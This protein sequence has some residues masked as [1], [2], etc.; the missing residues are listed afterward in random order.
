MSVVFLIKKHE[1]S[2]KYIDKKEGDLTCSGLMYRTVPLLPVRIPSLF[3]NVTS[4][5]SPIFIWFL[6]TKNMLPGYRKQKQYLI[7]KYQFD[8]WLS[9]IQIICSNSYHYIYL[10]R[11]YPYTDFHKSGNLISKIFKMPAE[12]VKTLLSAEK[13]WGIAAFKCLKS[14]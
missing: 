8:G 4:P 10:Q 9:H 7:Y 3:W 2:R 1:R 14:C 5:K 13:A 12:E 6:S 11:I